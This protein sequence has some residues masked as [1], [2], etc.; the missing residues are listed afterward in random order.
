MV[1]TR[2][3]VRVLAGLCVGRCTDYALQRDDG[4]YVRAFARLTDEVLWRHLAGGHTIGTYVID[5]RGWCPF[6][7]FDADS[8]EALLSL[9]DVQA[10]LATDGIPSYLEGSRRGGHLWVFLASLIAASLV[11]RWLLPYCP[12]GMEFYPKQE[13]ASLEHPGSLVRVPF[14]VHRLSG[15]RYPFVSWRDGQLVPVANSMAAALAWL[16][17]VERALVPGALVS[18]LVDQVGP[19]ATKKYVAEQGVMPATSGPKMSIHDWCAS[20]DAVRVIGRYVRLDKRGMG[21]CPFGEHHADGKDSRP[22]LWVHPPRSAGAPCW[23]CHVWQRG[24]NL[25]DFLLLYYGLD[26]RS[27]WQRIL[28]GETF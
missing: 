14:G 7:V 17:G 24:G 5:E 3:H 28:S 8:D 26:A 1:I 13:T 4:L 19:A 20:Q 23:Y 25:F 2:A 22:S 18:G 27:L 11:R 9:L 15:R 21:C 16:S 10:C 6:A 12:G